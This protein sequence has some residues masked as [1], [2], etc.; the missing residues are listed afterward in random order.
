[1]TKEYEAAIAAHDAA[2]LVYH[3]VRDRYRAKKADIHEFISALEIYDNAT[4]KF[5]KAFSKESAA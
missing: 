4:A 3:A 1:M 2:I 5:D